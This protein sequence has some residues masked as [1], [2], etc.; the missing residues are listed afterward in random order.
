MSWFRNA[1]FYEVPVR[2]FCDSNADGIG[3][4]GGLT[5]KLDYLQWLGVDC[6]W[7]PPF[8]ASPLKDGGYDVSDYESV[9]PDFG[10]MDDVKAFITEAH[11]R[12]LRVIADLVVNHTSSEHA[13]FQEARQPGSPKRDWY[14]W[15]DTADRWPEARVIFIDTEESN[16]AWDEVAGAYYWHRFFSHQPDLNF[17]NPEVVEAVID[18]VRFWLQLGF[19]GLRLDAIP[20]LVE[21][22][23]TNCDN[24]PETHDIIKLI[25]AVVDVEF[26]DAVLVAEANQIATDVVEYF[27]DGDECHM[28]YHFPVM[29]P[30]YMSLRRGDTDKLIKAIDETPDIPE[31]SQWGMFLRNHDELTLEMVTPEERDW[32]WQEYA[33]EPRMRSNLGIRRRLSPLLN[34]DRRQ[35]ELLNGL[36]LS[37]PGSPFLYYGDEIGM[38]DNIWLNDRDGVRTPMQ[39][40]QS[41]GAGFSAAPTDTF[42]LPLIDSP[43]YGPAVVSVAA[44]QGDAASLLEWTRRVLDVRRQ[45][46][47]FGTGSF[48]RIETDNRALLVFERTSET[49]SILVVTNF[50]DG[51]QRVEGVVGSAT[52]LIAGGAVQ[53]ADLEL[54]AFGF[55]W[56]LRD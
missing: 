48:D 34:G 5:S 28:C 2:A 15:N 22:D 19:D 12:G 52:D 10:T 25:R 51:P 27:G 17:D 50:S 38:G 36:L 42:Q 33:P 1:V 3:D 11:A 46:Q 30:M 14:V 47:A 24:L 44:Q 40:D 23:G 8:F 16:W 21:R 49:E 39:W 37:L 9:H 55:R 45:H 20:Y 26:P 13:W 56:L 6:L 31:G 54:P 18:V 4:F 41:A 7:L 43:A 29:P 32:M 53:L 35:I